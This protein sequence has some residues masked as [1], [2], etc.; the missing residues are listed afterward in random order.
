[1]THVLNK[2]KG[3]APMASSSQKN[4]AY[5]YDRKFTSRCYDHAVLPSHHMVAS[6]S[7]YA[8]G[9]NRTRHNHVVSHAPRKVC[10]SPTTIYHACNAPF[11]LSR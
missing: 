2:E 7:T 6:S 11:A 9:R 4:Q 3:K 1:M 8:N 10:N 5:T